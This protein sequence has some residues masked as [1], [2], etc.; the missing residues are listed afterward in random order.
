M[1]TE[2]YKE[3]K[4]N[5]EFHL[6][7]W[8]ILTKE[9][10][11]SLAIIMFAGFSAIGFTAQYIEKEAPFFLIFALLLVSLHLLTV[12]VLIVHHCLRASN[13]MPAANE[14]KNL[15]HPDFEWE[16][17]LEADLENLQ[18]SIESNAES[19]ANKGKWLNR[20]RYAAFAVVFTFFLGV[21]LGKMLEHFSWAYF[22]AQIF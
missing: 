17:I 3:G 14:P 5:L 4:E 6:K 11:T 16:E 9:A 20:L 1:I 22:L 19:C 12:S 21:Y 2:I 8:D 15:H 7:N 18:K 13:V 10:N